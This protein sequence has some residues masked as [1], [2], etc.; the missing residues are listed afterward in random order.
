MSEMVISAAKKVPIP[1]N[2]GG[3]G[4]SL[5]PLA[6][7]I[8]N[9]EV[10]EMREVTNTTQ[11]VISSAATAAKKRNPERRFTVRRLSNNQ[12]GETVFGIW[13]VR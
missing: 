3:F 11:G 1:V 9:L 12:E 10:G 13:R 6:V 4:R 5:G 2:T 8:D 7:A